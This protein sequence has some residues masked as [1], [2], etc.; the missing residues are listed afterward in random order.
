MLR[1]NGLSHDPQQAAIVLGHVT[2]PLIGRNVGKYNKRILLEVVS[3]QGAFFEFD[4]TRKPS[5][6]ATSASLC[7]G[8]CR[9]GE[10][11]SG[12]QC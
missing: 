10:E 2:K 9:S 8:D 1:S 4:V 7:I 6:A 12:H 5:A 11:S 3:R